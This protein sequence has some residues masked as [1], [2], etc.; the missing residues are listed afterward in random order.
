MDELLQLFEDLNI[1][2]ETIKEIAAQASTNPMAA[3]AALQEHMSPEMMQQLMGYLMTH[4]DMLRELGA[5]A[6]VSVEQI[7][8]IR[9]QMGTTPA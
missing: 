1:P 7:D 8:R 2:E 4:P 3:V 6:G 5:Y 9:D